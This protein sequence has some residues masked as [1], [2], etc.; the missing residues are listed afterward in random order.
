MPGGDGVE[1]A[2]VDGLGLRRREGVRAGRR[3]AGDHDQGHDRGGAHGGGHPGDPTPAE[4]REIDDAQHGQCGQGRRELPQSVL[5]QRSARHARTRVACHPRG[6][7]APVRT[8]ARLAG[9]Y[10]RARA[11]G[12]LRGPPQRARVGSGLHARPRTAAPDT[13]DGR[14]RPG[15]SRRQRPCRAVPPKGL[16]DEAPQLEARQRAEDGGATR[17]PSGGPARRRARAV[18]DVPGDHPLHLAQRRQR[19]DRATAARSPAASRPRSSSSSGTPDHDPA[20]PGP[21]PGGT[22]GSRRPPGR[23]GGRGRCAGR[24]PA[25]APRPPS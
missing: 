7:S 16:G 4:R 8:G 19:A 13:W 25:P 5:L 21:P 1:D 24:A 12:N 14:L 18:R 6:T 15:R 10:H 22:R 3:E 17:A 9:G 23:R 20:P 2:R 11:G